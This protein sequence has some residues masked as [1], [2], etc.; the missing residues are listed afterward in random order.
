MRAL[1]WSTLILGLAVPATAF[2]DVEIT[3]EP[4]R[5]YSIPSDG[6]EIQG[7]V[8]QSSASGATVISNTAGEGDSSKCVVLIADA[9][10]ATS[11]EYQFDG[12]PTACTG[13]LPHPNGGVFIRGYNPMAMEGD[14]TG[15]TTYIDAEGNE[16]WK[17]PDQLLVDASP[18]PAGT[19][20]F[21]GN[22]VVPI[23]V[24]AYSP[25]LDKLLAFTAGQL[26]IG[27]DVKFITQAHVINVEAGVLAESGQ[28]FGQSGVGVP[29]AAVVRDDGNFVIYY[30]SPGA[31]G[32]DYY[33]YNGRNEIDFLNPANEEW[34][35]RY[36]YNMVYGDRSLHYIWSDANEP[37][38]QSY[39]T[40]TNDEGSLFFTNEYDSSY[41]FND[42]ETA[43][44][45][46]PTN[47]WVT[48]QY[49]I[50]SYVGDGE[51][52]L[53]FVDING[54]TPG[55][56]RLST[57]APDPPAS[58]VEHEGVVRL[59][60]YNELDRKITEYELSFRDAPEFNPDLGFGDMGLDMDI[61]L[62]DVLDEVGCGCRTVASQ[63]PRESGW[64]I[65][66]V[67][68]FVGILRRR[69]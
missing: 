21:L 31:R 61:G 1:L 10:G 14:V 12:A 22:Y 3:G 23:G 69:K 36:V 8:V 34:A 49:N 33:V 30:Y 18:E 48:P 53:R 39:L 27:Q 52:Y 16:A 28:T 38:A 5:E 9:D 17:I 45:G 40:V 58:L 15:F 55:M 41:L 11:I 47:V 35:Q 64:V 7:A 46:P 44:L 43:I 51:V 65:A 4:L 2:A 42:A 6:F 62:T 57:V 19:G 63:L 20:E 32:A 50:I 66:L 29:G 60:T 68:G 54:E 59:L 13:V 67:L 56:G 24:L 25:T 26:T 37:G